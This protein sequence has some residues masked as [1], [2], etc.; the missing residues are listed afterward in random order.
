MGPRGPKIDYTGTI[1]TVFD[2]KITSPTSVRVKNITFLLCV[3]Q[4]FGNSKQSY[5]FL[6]FQTCKQNMMNMS[7]NKNIDLFIIQNFRSDLRVTRSFV[8]S[9]ADGALK[10]ENY[11]STLLHF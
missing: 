10:P 2:P 8:V 11:L 1:L 6:F 5:V 3:L 4:I 9:A 7:K